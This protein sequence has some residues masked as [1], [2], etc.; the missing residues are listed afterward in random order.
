VGGNTLHY[1]TL[2]HAEQQVALDA[3]DRDLT[4]RLNHERRVAFQF[5]SQ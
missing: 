2:E 4:L 3:V 5:P 1:F